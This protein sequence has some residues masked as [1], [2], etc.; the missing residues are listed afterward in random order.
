MSGIAWK[1][2]GTG[3]AVVFLHGVG[4]GA[5]SWDAQLAEIGRTHR[6]LAWDMPGYGASD[7]LAAPGFEA[8]V[9]ALVAWLDAAG[10]ARCT[11]VGHSIGGMIAQLFAARHPG[12]VTRLVLSATSAAFGNPDGDFQKGFLRA[13][14]APLD[15]G[16]SM[17]DLAGE[18]VPTLVGPGAPPEACR[19]AVQVMSR[20]RP[21]TYRS[22]MTAL[23]GFDARPVL[24]RISAPALLI[25]GEADPAAPVRAMER[26]AA[27][28]GDA[29]LERVAG[30]GH[31][32]NIEMPG[33]YGALVRGALDPGAANSIPDGIDWRGDP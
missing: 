17:A 1:E 3:A 2:R 14:L 18:F 19:A 29:R 28:L 30:M 22:A 21:E 6:A 16:R 11:L 5:E 12:R 24:D 10:V 32:G 27:R 33:R 8:W 9:E 25:A 7:D 15:A 23:V 20:V 31:L 26:L 4:G 13:R